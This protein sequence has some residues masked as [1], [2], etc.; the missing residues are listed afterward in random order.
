MEET[1]P[2]A[3]IGGNN[4]PEQT[5]FELISQEIADLFD[6]AKIWADG[7][8]IPDEATHDAVTK[9]YDMLHEAGKRADALRKVEKDP[10]DEAVKEIQG[11]FNP[12]IQ[13]K[14]GLVSMAKSSLNTLLA[15]YRDAQRIAR[16]KEAARIAQIAADAEAAARAAMTASAGNL[17]ARVEAEQEVENA[18]AW[19][20]AARSA[21]KAATTGLGL[22]TV[23]FCKIEDE[24]DALDW[25]FGKDPARFTA[26]V[27]T[28]ADE[29]V[30][31]GVRSIAGVK[32]WDE[33]R[34]N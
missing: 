11:R 28:M 5:P 30:R 20:K 34:A 13:E 32:I 29:A 4:P 22:R 31:M 9:L 19:G 1:N 3:V 15:A 27:Q 21:D 16:E 18:K 14:R 17:E 2:R 8:P 24:G 26:L 10:H 7:Q 23:W 33:K 12:L 25:A 6:E